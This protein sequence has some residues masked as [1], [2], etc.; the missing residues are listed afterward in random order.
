MAAVRVV[1]VN[2]TPRWKLPLLLLFPTVTV[3][4]T[5]V[6][7]IDGPRDARAFCCSEPEGGERG[8]L[9]R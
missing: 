1:V 9:V 3:V 8:L 6:V 5:V 7:V 2:V 4:V